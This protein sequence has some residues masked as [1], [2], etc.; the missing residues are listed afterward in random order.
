MNSPDIITDAAFDEALHRCG[1]S[2]ASALALAVS[3]GGDSMALAVLCARVLLP[4]GVRLKA[5]TVDHGLRSGVRAEAEAAGKTLAALGIV[6]EILVWAAEEKPQ[7]HVQE[8]ARDARYALLADACRRDGFDALLTAH[9]AEDQME[10]FWM[11]LAHGSGLDGLAAIAPQR[12]L[13]CGLR[14][15]R[16]LLGFSRAALRDVCQAANIGW[17]EDPTNENGTFLRARLRGFEEV[18]A[19]EGLTPARLAQV[20][21]KLADAR[22]ALEDIA[23]EKTAACAAVYP[24]GYVRLDA[25]ALSALPDDLA[26][27]VLS[28]LLLLVAPADYPP[29][30]ERLDHLRRDLARTGFAGA[31]AFGCEIT[32]RDAAGMALIL[33]EAA[34]LPAAT[35]VT[36]AA[37]QVWD[38]RFV[39]TG[40]PQRSGES[41]I[42]RPLGAAGV[43]ALRKQAAADKNIIAALERLPG[44]LRATLPALFS[45]EKL[46]CVPHLSW[47]DAAAAADCSALRVSFPAKTA[48]LS[49]RGDCFGGA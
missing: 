5:Y 29:G 37:A 39:L 11:R 42:L 26:R 1:L 24:E 6:Q 48:G 40:L 10:T 49:P 12:R 18:L 41:L 9:Q 28:R 46:L 35:A 34:A 33:R 15:V 47:H 43:A 4:R 16:P 3:G 27:R 17:A 31:T 19:A 13:P 36:A 44:K 7:S 30:F 23:A 20:T 38:G 45:G 8:R 2:G 21:Q 25:A 32:A 22:A 14:L